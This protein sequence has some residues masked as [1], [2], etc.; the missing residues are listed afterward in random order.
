LSVA[1]ALSNG[2]SLHARDVTGQ[3]TARVSDVPADATVGELVQG[4]VTRM[5]LP[6]NDVQGRP[7]NYHARLEREG[8]HLRASETCGEA[9]H[10]QDELVL[11][12]HITAG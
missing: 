2:L 10:E 6:P 5:G 3:K 8:R 12:P 11:Q 1:T 9:L 7:L 4:L